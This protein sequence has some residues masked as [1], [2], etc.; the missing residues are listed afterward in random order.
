[1]INAT[2]NRSTYCSILVLFSQSAWNDGSVRLMPHNDGWEHFTM[3]A[4]GDGSKSFRSAHGTYLSAWP[5]GVR[6]AS[7][8]QGWEH[9]WM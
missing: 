6:L 7:H 5:D 8:N 9:F 3:I 4:N 2:R 1:M